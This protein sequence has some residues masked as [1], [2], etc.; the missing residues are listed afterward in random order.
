[1]VLAAWYFS[2]SASANLDVAILY[3]AKLV[4]RRSDSISL[5]LL[6]NLLAKAE[7]SELSDRGPELRRA[8][9]SLEG[10]V[11]EHAE[12]IERI[13]LRRNKRI[14]HLEVKAQLDELDE[15]NVDGTDL[16]TFFQSAQSAL[17]AL[18]AILPDYPIPKEPYPGA[19]DL[20]GREDLTDL[21][22]FA[23]EAYYSNEV[24]SPSDLVERT[25]VLAKMRVVRSE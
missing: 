4:E 8:S 19:E 11:E 2:L 20:F 7:T 23:R 13:R 6:T 16:R 15:M 12:T 1:M 9:R 17:G 3:A 21:L 25:R 10:L 24:G 5:R 14:A 18:Y 22:H